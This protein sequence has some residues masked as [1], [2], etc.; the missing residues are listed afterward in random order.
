MSCI[1]LKLENETIAADLDDP[2]DYV[3]RCEGGDRHEVPVFA[4]MKEKRIYYPVSSDNPAVDFMFKLGNRLVAFHITRQL[5]EEIQLSVGAFEK[6]LQEVEVTREDVDF[7]LVPPPYVVVRSRFSITDFDATKDV[8][9]LKTYLDMTNNYM[10]S[11][12]TSKY[13]WE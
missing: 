11:V 12:P 13:Q 7:V 9:D 1:K 3:M 8:K 10:L 5:T 2:K 6:F 4:T